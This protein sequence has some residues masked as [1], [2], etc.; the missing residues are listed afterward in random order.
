MQ[1]MNFGSRVQGLAVLVALMLLPTAYAVAGSNRDNPTL[2][3]L[4]PGIDWNA[5][6]TLEIRLE[7]YDYIPNEFELRRDTPYRLILNNISNSVTH[8]LVDL[9]FFHAVVLDKIHVDGVELTTPHIHQLKLRPNSKATLYLVP[10]LVGAYA[11]YC[12]VPGHK[13]EGM[14]GRV[15]IIP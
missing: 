5:A 6:A 2:D 15:S 8:D 14:D 11:I 1:T 4:P 12:S 3:W 13:A 9:A 7:D 10:K